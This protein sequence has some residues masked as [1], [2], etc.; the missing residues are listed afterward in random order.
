MG[1]FIYPSTSYVACTCDQG[2][3]NEIEKHCLDCEDCQTLNILLHLCSE[4]P[5][6]DE[7]QMLEVYREAL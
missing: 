3:K 4:D 7:Q 6:A 2:V 5:T 1:L